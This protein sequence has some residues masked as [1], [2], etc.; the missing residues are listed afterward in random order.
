MTTVIGVYSNK[1]GVGKT[2]TAV[3]LSYIA[4]QT[5]QKTLICDLDPQSSSTFYFRVKPKLQKKA[6]GLV[7]AGK[8]IDRS[9]KGT[10]YENLDLLPAE[11]LT[12]TSMSLTTRCVT[13]RNGCARSSSPLRSQYDLIFFRLSPLD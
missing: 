12:A 3:N 2:A 6:V 11:F 13:A 4:A 7:K 9:I 1:G 10:D 5:G 8:S